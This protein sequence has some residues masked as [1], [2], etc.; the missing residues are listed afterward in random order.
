MFVNGNVDCSSSAIEQLNNYD[1]QGSILRVSVS[2][3]FITPTHDT[4]VALS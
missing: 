1:Y 4:H 2:L 3:S